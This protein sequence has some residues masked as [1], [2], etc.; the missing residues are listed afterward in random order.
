M[1]CHLRVVERKALISASSGIEELKPALP[2]G[3]DIMD[4]LRDRDLESRLPNCKN[5]L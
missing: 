5:R 1:Y 3:G 4:I 2:V